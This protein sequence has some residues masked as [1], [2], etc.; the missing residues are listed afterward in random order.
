MLS[1]ECAEAFFYNR[2]KVLGRT[3]SPFS[4]YHY[5]VLEAID[6]PIIKKDQTRI[7]IIDLYIATIV[8]SNKYPID[9][10]AFPS[11]SWW[12]IVKNSIRFGYF[13]TRYKMSREATKFSN[14]IKDYS[15]MPMFWESKDKK[16]SSGLPDA[17]SLVVSLIVSLGYKEQDAWNCPLGKAVWLTTASAILNGAESKIISPQAKA[18]MDKV[19]SKKSE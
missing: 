6:S 13:A 14:Y 18:F 4:L 5:F 7:S 3:L 1:V 8:C 15:S 17:L 2:H 19:S 12:S 10:S 11:G 16:K 9:I